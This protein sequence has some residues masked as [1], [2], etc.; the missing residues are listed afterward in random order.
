MSLYVYVEC[1]QVNVIAFFFCVLVYII[2]SFIFFIFLILYLLLYVLCTVIMTNKLYHYGLEAQDT[3]LQHSQHKNIKT[4]N[5]SM[6][7]AMNN[8]SVGAGRQQ[9]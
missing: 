1:T 5:T 7:L 2:F 3:T 6:F 8:Y 9:Y 4:Q